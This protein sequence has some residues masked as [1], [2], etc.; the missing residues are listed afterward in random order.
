MAATTAPEVEMN[1]FPSDSNPTEQ[2]P[3]PSSADGDD[4]SKV[5]P[6]TEAVKAD[7]VDAGTAST[8]VQK[9]VK[10]A[11][12]FGMPVQLS[13]EEKRNS[14]AERFGTGTASQ[15]SD[16]SKQS[17][18]LKRKARAERF[19]IAQSAPADEEAKKKARGARF[20]SVT[21]TDSAEEEK[22]KARELR[23]SQPQSG[24]LSKA[25]IEGNNEKTAIASKAGE[26]T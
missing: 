6:I 4:E 1:K 15:G 7:D 5:K 14:R 10:R 24:S 16:L 9:K 23:F 21:K 26:G 12:R 25:K 17:E 13:E 20:G 22:K 2:Q 11:E 8:D 19:G 18:D 3:P